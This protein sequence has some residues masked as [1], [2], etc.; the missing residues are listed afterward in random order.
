MRVRLAAALV[1]IALSVFYYTAASEHARSVNTSKARGDQSGYLW[2]AQQVYWNWHGRNPPLLIGQRMRMPG[3]AAVLALFW[4]PGMSDPEFFERAKTV[5]IWL[6]MALLVGFAFI[7]AWSLPYLA[8]TN[9]TLIVAF[10]YFVF[11]AGYAQPELLSY[12]LFFCMFLSSWHLLMSSA[13]GRRSAMLAACTGALAGLTHLTKAV[14]PWFLAVLVAALLFKG[15]RQRAD[16]R[17]S[18]AAAALL[19]A[20]FL[21]VVYPYI[22]N[23]KQ[24]F[25][26]YFYNTTT[27]HYVWYDNGA[28]GR[29]R[30]GPYTDPEGRI[31]VPHEQLPTMTTYL[32]TR[33]PREIAAR[34]A[35][36][37][38]DMLVRSYTSYAYLKYVVLY[39]LAAAIVM[40]T[41][42]RAFRR[43]AQERA[44][45]ML[46]LVMYAVVFL[47]STALLE[48][49]SG[50]GTA[51]FLIAHLAPLLFVL[52]RFLTSPPFS[53]TA[54]Q[55]GS[56]RLSIT[57]FH[58]IVTVILA[59]D[60]AFFLWPRLMSTYGGF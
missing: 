43:L 57:H 45:L 42:W 34:L 19:I 27:T 7:F 18:T 41:N 15:L 32:A 52:S 44:A 26:S 49:M 58:Q 3:Y 10:G 23:S 22:A 60:L 13:D 12:F 38:E 6:S 35:H 1:M 20:A 48:A 11:K 16:L 31:S 25:G 8:A 51:R 30:L 36:G 47:T 40:I 46:F 50:T 37:F 24:V 4:D 39:V 14:A 17:R 59:V 55:A 54:W 5:N 53:E 56:V 28:D 29:A 33:S 21:A 9:L 2:D